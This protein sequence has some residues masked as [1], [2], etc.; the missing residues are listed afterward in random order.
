[1]KNIFVLAIWICCGIPAF[2]VRYH[3]GQYVTISKPVFE[4]VYVAGG[5]IIVNAP[6]HGDLVIAGGT[7]I[8]NDSVYNDILLGAGTVSFNGF[9][10]GDI[11]CAG[12]KLEINK[13]VTG[14]IVV[15]GGSI[16]VG[17]DAF[18]GSL[19][20]SGGNVTIDGSVNGNLSGVFNELVLNGRVAENAECRGGRIEIKGSIEGSSVLSAKTLKIDPGASFGGN[21]RYWTKKGEIDFGHTI[22]NGKAIF[23]PSLRFSAGEWYFLGAATI[24]GFLLYT[25]MVL[26]LIF[27]IQ[28]LF[29]ST[30]KNAAGMALEHSLRSLLTGFLFLLG[31]PVAIV[32]IFVTVIGIPV[33]ILLAGTYI[34]V[35]LLSMIITAVVIANW[36]NNYNNRNWNF[37]RI[38]LAALVVYV[39]LKLFSM[40][41]FVG[42]FVMLFIVAMALGSILLTI[43]VKNKQKAEVTAQ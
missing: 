37:W 6:V 5:T 2:A 15:A 24:T 22:E 25:G 32:I 34:V 36:I 1:M 10:G 30:M 16:H 39:L 21:V 20:A 40:M 27:V 23:D 13:Q 4:N 38:S 14:D 33:S 35:L 42:W 28:Y 19:L 3:Y 9:V 11:R 43:R 8:I 17:M 41:P 26:V 31:V 18:T 29:A 7:V 12:G